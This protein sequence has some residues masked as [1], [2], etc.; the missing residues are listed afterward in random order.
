[1]YRTQIS[2]CERSHHT[3]IPTCKEFKTRR[4]IVVGGRL[5]L[6]Q[7]LEFPC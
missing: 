7:Q 6:Q 3:G 2:H 5:A 4:E 1:M